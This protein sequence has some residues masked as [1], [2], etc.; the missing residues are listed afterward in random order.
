MPCRMKDHLQ[1]GNLA[2]TCITQRGQDAQQRVERERARRRRE[3]EHELAVK[4][5]LDN[6]LLVTG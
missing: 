2:G 3:G 6:D 5:E 4:P 1:R